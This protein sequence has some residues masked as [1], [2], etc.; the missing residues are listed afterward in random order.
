MPAGWYEDTDPEALGVF[1]QLHRQMTPGQRVA[2]VF[3]LSA[4]QESLEN[5]ELPVAS[6]EDTVLA[7]LVWF[8]KGGE[9]SDRQWH[10]IL[11]VVNVQS[12]RLDRSYLD[13]WAGELGVADLLR[14]ALPQ[15]GF[16]GRS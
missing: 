9:V 14:N 3:E 16:R 2:R 10:D 6:P 5:I 7:K 13:R 12:R 4:F 8:R 1:L 15:E 11:G